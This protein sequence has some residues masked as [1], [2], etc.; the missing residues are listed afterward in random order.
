MGFEPAPAAHASVDRARIA[1]AAS[2][3]GNGT[4]GGGRDRDAAMPM[5]VEWQ[6][7]WCHAPG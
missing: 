5:H 6:E 1:A 7:H 2:D 4:T 3:G